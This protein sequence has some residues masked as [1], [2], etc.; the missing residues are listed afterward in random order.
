M[1]SSTK[2]ADGSMDGGSSGGVTMI[3]RGV[4]ME[5]DFTSQGDVVIEGEVHGTLS[6]GGKLTVG[7]EAV[8][9][10]DVTANEAEVA[11]RIEGNLH[12]SHE[13]ILHASARVKGDV[14]VEHATIES[15]AA[16]EGKV[17]IGK[18]SSEKIEN[19]GE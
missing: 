7:S 4:K 3:A 11:G 2:R 6:T 15:G 13:L 19:A 10:A 12:L 16:L 1:F 18:R 9:K 8:I 14:T 5:G 17:E